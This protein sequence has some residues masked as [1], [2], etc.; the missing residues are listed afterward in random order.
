MVSGVMVC[1]ENEESKNSGHA[2]VHTLRVV[3][4]TLPPNRPLRREIVLRLRDHQL[5]KEEDKVR[6]HMAFPTDS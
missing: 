4:K 5:R 2:N 6:A 1:V 3:L